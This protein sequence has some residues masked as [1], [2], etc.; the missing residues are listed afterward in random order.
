MPMES[1]GCVLLHLMGM[2]VQWSTSVGTELR[3]HPGGGHTTTATC[4]DD[5]GAGQST[6]ISQD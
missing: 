1:G 2:H 3:M 6:A 5:E 4:N